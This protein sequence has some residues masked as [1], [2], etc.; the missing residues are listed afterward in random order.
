M[1]LNE[2]MVRKP[3]DIAVISNENLI[4]NQIPT[5]KYSK[6]DSSRYSFEY[7]VD[8][9]IEVNMFESDRQFA[10]EEFVD[11]EFDMAVS[12][13]DHSYYIVAAASGVITGLL[14]Q[15]KLTP[16]M[17]EKVNEWKNKDWE[18]YIIIA[19]QIAG[20]KK[21]DYKSAAKF[22]AD[23]FV[24]IIGDGIKEEIRGGL[25]VWMKA[26]SNHPS[27]A[28]LIFSVIS[29]FSGNKYQFGDDG[30][31]KESLPDYY[32]IGRNP[33]E[34][35]IYAILYW[36]F[37]LSVNAAIS[38]IAIVEEINIPKEVISLIKDLFKLPMFKDISN[39]YHD[40]EILFSK[41]IIN[42][43][44]KSKYEGED[45]K[46]SDFDIHEVMSAFSNRVIEGCIPV[47]INE[48]F[49]RAFYFI[50]KF[51]EEAKNK[52]IKSF[53]E[54]KDINVGSIL[55]F[56][57]RLL[58]RMILISSGCFVGINLGGAVIKAVVKHK[59]DGEGFAE[60]LLTEINVAGVGRFVLACVAD[61]KY[62]SDDIKIAL[63][64]KDRKRKVSEAEEQQQIV[65]DMIS[66]DVFKVLSLTPAQT[67]ALYSMEAILVKKDIEHTKD[68]DSKVNKKLWLDTWKDVIISGMEID[69]PDYFVSDE[70]AMYD[71]FYGLS[72]DDNNNRW[73]YLMAM[74]LAI[75][76]PYYYL[77]VG[78]DDN[79]KKLKRADYNYIDDQF[80]RR[81]TIVSQ[82]EI[83]A[84]R[85]YY[86]K[87]IGMISGKTSNMIIA[88]GVA[89]AAAI[90]TGGFAFAFAPGIATL[91]AGEAVVGLHGAALTSASLAFVGGGS[92]AAGGL[93]MAGGT[94]IITGGGA[95]IG[96]AGSGSASM[97][98]ILLQ[99]GSDYWIRQSAKLLTFCKC[100]L[101]DRLNDVDSIKALSYELLQTIN[102]VD[103]NIKELEAEDCSLDKEAIKNSKDCLK[104]LT[105]CQGELEKMIK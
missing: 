9:D 102:K 80:V 103:Q 35:M 23:R 61:S 37:N 58:S 75:F 22:L 62:W 85:D 60:A 52:E 3:A 16:E 59:K 87:Y 29:Q 41:W 13:R 5:V 72:K 78:N 34:K 24:P 4:F 55:P 92:L 8:D 32:A 47:L 83:D 65:D 10:S 6:V 11:A 93:G 95:I 101:K 70:N 71:A 54:L 46:E 39:N 74:E 69:I 42:T 100:V 104:Y 77:G 51:I 49:V 98:A 88:A 36:I 44:E 64:R 91:I 17:L 19:A 56:N 57:N 73:F 28:G 99:T 76:K 7:K 67:R 97:A 79:F 31:E 1:G 63:Q 43:F 12:E 20:F 25:D 86:K 45:G 15:L 14:S 53:T 105:K 94:A 66:K 18:K 81:Q 33:E 89:G 30:L 90:L 50:K 26:L 40:A 96:I 48:C 38:E 68:E 84:F 82:T 27:L 21:A 2:L